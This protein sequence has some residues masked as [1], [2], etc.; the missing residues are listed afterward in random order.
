MSAPP[1]AARV[2]LGILNGGKQRRQAIR[3][4]VRPPP[5]A[6]PTLRYPNVEILKLRRTPMGQIEIA[7]RTDIAVILVVAQIESGYERVV[8]EEESPV[9]KHGDQEMILA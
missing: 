2:T 7:H 1:R 6:N 3:R 8:D 9:A 4:S 5:A